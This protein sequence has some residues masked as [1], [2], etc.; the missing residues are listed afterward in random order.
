MAVFN[1]E[2][3]SQSYNIAL[4]KAK[5]YLE[6]DDQDNGVIYL[7]KA[8]VLSNELINNCVINEVRNRLIE[9]NQLLKDILISIIDNH[10][11]PFIE[12]GGIKT[13]RNESSIED[14]N[15]GSNSSN[16][17]SSLNGTNRGRSTS[18]S[19]RVD[20]SESKDGFFKK[21]Y[22]SINLSDVAGLDEVKQEIKLNIITP[23]KYPD[24]YFKYKDTLGCR[25]L[26]YGPPGCGKSFI[27]EA[28]A[29]ELKC[30]YAL[31]NAHDILEKYVGEA[32]KK[33][34]Q[35]FK[36]AEKYDNC[37]I[38]FD[39]LDALFASRESDDS[40]YTKDI[41]TTFLTCL[42]GFNT[43][44][45]DDKIRIIIG[46]TNRPWS[47]DSALLRGKRFDT[48]IYVGLP[49]YNARKFLISKMYKKHPNLVVNTDLSLEFLIEKLEGYSSADIETILDKVNSLALKRALN[50]KEQGIE[51]D[52]VITLA[53]FNTVLSNYR[54]SITAE[55]LEAFEAFKK[56]VI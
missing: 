20:K 41:L 29:G 34:M 8:I 23:L 21:N 26:M 10:L 35:I 22:P 48:Q 50:N 31:I 15:T 5:E 14:F 47:L 11:N 56:G 51:K 3:K 25:I 30:A 19:T 4:S 44:K 40:R 18:S 17:G 7:K 43:F 6:K 52:E 9:E 55:S 33:V 38:F 37:L 13:T 36:E 39:E 27:A 2:I 54:N 46:A 32:P 45:D 1:F 49:D 53:D 16:R 42:S 28:I 24:M 12:G